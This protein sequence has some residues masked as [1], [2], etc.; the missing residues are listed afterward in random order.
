MF[1]PP[2]SA[3]EVTRA[4]KPMRQEG[5]EAAIEASGPPGQ[6]GAGVVIG[7]HELIGGNQGKWVNQLGEWRRQWQR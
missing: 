3:L 5:A 2:E 4:H 6:E 1:F 7:M